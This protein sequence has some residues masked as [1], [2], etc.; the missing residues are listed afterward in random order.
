MILKSRSL[1]F[2]SVSSLPSDPKHLLCVLAL[3]MPVSRAA[4]RCAR[5]PPT[6]HQQRVYNRFTTSPPGL[7]QGI[8]Q[9]KDTAF[10]KEK[11]SLWIALKHLGD[12]PAGYYLESVTYASS[13]FPDVPT[14][15]VFKYRKRTFQISGLLEVAKL[16]R[17]LFV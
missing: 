7:Y 15:L 10:V 2:C 4:T 6:H 14:Q 3:T 11:V 12:E 9:F 8:F 16:L 5:Q 13:N 1:T 17:F